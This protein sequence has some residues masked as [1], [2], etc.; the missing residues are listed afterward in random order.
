MIKIK[1][2][3]GLMLLLFMMSCVNNVVKSA[4]SA[5]SFSVKQVGVLD[6]LRLD[7]SATAYRIDES[8]EPPKE[9]LERVASSDLFLKLGSGEVEKYAPIPDSV[10][11][12]GNQPFLLGILKAYQEHRPIVISP[13]IIWLLIEQGFARHIAFHAEKFRDRLVGFDGKRE[14]TVVVDTTQVKLG[15]KGS[16]W[17]RVFPQ[18]VDQ[19]SAYTGEEYI[20]NLRA[21]FSTSNETSKIASAIVLMESVKIYFD[22]RMMVI[23][24]GISSV[25]IEGTA[26]D[27]KK[28][29]DKIDYIETFDLAWWTK[30]L[31]SIIQEIVKTK[32]GKL[33][34]E[35]WK[36]MVQLQNKAVYSPHETIDGWITKFY[37]FNDKGE[38][39]NLDPITHASSIA[40]EYVKVPFILD[41]R[42][43]GK[44]YAMEFWAGLFGMEQ[45]TRNYRLRPLVGWAIAHNKQSTIAAVST[46][47]KDA[48][49]DVSLKNI[50][51]IP[52]QFFALKS[53][54]RL[55]IGFIGKVNIPDE[56]R[57]IK[58]KRMWVTGEISVEE[59]R[60]LKELL[61]DTWLSVNGREI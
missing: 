4:K 13:D 2:L 21:D 22:Y 61:P 47:P 19:I 32:E 26:A 50:T 1:N 29:L 14:L 58:I 30:E 10:V 55:V 51:E 12:F 53:I 17:E 27:W 36:N 15:D 7:R 40:A 8:L 28:I 57:S 54:D 9:L 52:R 25:T 11:Y 41:D 3:F 59:E 44:Q 45:D 24:C 46:P 42:T 16:D 43:S 48:Y 18:F 34:K 33:D 31:R 60:R 39:R 38:R 37:P 56:I 6:T 23:G 20:G 49:D 35:F 5:Q